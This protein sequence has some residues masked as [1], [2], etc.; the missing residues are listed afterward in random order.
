MENLLIY[1]VENLLKYGAVEKF[2]FKIACEEAFIIYL[3]HACFALTR[4]DIM[5]IKSA[6]EK[7]IA[8]MTDDERKIWNKLF[9]LL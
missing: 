6:C 2:N 5:L 4:S 7:R 8:Y 1:L 3:E 9:N